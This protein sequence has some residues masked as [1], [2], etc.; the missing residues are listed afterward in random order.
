MIETGV[1]HG[2]FQILHNDHL[3]YI[4]A[5]KAECRHLV[6]GVTNPDP[7]LTR[8][9]GADLQRSRPE[10]NPL[11]YYERYHMVRAVLKE[12]GLDHESYSVVPLPINYPELFQYYAPLTATFFLT[13]YDAW[14][15]SKLQRLKDLGVLTRV[16]WERPEKG[17]TATEIRRRIIKDLPWEDL[18]P[19]ATAGL[20]KKWGIDQRLKAGDGA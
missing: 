1:V 5:A 7:M 14:G 13:I 9:D 19:P 10:S 8:D 17:L 11:T 15:R 4:M 6:V 20:I 18:V 3:I 12:A 2:R 16:L